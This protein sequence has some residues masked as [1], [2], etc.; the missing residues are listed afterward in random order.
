MYIHNSQL[1]GDSLDE[2]E[3]I[4]HQQSRVASCRRCE[5][6]RQQ[7]AVVTQFTISCAAE[8]LR[9]VTSD[10]IMTS[11]LKMLSI[12]IK[13]HVVKPL[14]SVSKLLA[15]SIGSRRELVANC[16][17][18][19]DATQL[20]SCVALRVGSVY[21]A[22]GGHLRHFYFG[23]RATAQCCALLTYILTSDLW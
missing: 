18:T 23:S 11:L 12:S 22:L 1:V 10:D 2:S 8:L 21:W 9:L 19:A 20:H 17:L 14:R 3:Q 5:R 16:V 6:T 4:R 7:S 13:I 15:E